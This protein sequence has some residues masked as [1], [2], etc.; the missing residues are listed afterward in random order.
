MLVAALFR[1]DRVPQDV[2]DLAVHRPAV[3]IGEAHAVR[4]Q[5]GHVAIGQEK[6]VARVTQDRGHVRGD[7]VL[8]IAQADHHRRAQTRGHDLVRIE[9]CDTTASANTP[10]SSFT[11]SRTAFSRLPR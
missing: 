10:C 11:E 3:E 5:Y 1:H 4:R 7:E 8:A 9:S 2:R 6:H